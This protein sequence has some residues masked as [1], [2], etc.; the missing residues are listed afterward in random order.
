MP[1]VAWP[2]LSVTV[3]RTV[4][5]SLNVTVPVAELGVTVAVNVTGLPDLAVPAEEV[6]VVM[7]LTL[8]TVWVTALLVH[9]S[10]LS[11]PL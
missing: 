8:F 11:S 4:L 3:P 1:N 9:P 6:R 5:P 7:E 2:L 10:L